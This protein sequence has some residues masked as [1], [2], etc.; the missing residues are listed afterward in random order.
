[1]VQIPTNRNGFKSISKHVN[2]RQWLL[3]ASIF[4]EELGKRSKAFPRDEKFK[5][6]NR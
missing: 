2:I 1:M 6:R 3:E 4:A 5:I